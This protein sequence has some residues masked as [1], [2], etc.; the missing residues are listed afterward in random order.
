MRSTL[1]ICFLLCTSLAHASTLIDAQTQQP[2]PDSYVLV[3]YPHTEYTRVHAQSMNGTI[4][5][6]HPDIPF[7]LFIDTLETPG[8][9]YYRHTEPQQ[10][11]T[12]FPV[13]SL[14]GRIIKD[15]IVASRATLRF[16]CDKDY[17]IEYPEKA[18]ALGYFSIAYLPIGTCRIHSQHGNR[19]GESTITIQHGQAHEIT[20]ALDKE[21]PTRWWMYGLVLLVIIGI[22]IIFR[23]PKT[24]PHPTRKTTQPDVAEKLIKQREELLNT[25]AQDERTV[26]EYLIKHNYKATQPQIYKATNIPKT[27]LARQIIKLA[28]KNIVQTKRVRKIKE[29]QL[30][31]WFLNPKK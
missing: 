17:G 22:L 5:H 12:V 24:T 1:I 6:E 18:D 9:D 26:V 11:I 8:K 4:R 10:R 7:T 30:T 23:K 19:Y 14:N 15:T 29:I 25:L 16:D 13:G 21:L 27:T 20:L 31:D 28:N 3:T 2:I